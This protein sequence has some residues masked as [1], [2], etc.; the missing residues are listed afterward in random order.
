LQG[1]QEENVYRMEK[2]HQKELEQAPQKDGFGITG[3]H[4]LV[5]RLIIK[6]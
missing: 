3:I 4:Q 2:N 6:T 5:L 1:F